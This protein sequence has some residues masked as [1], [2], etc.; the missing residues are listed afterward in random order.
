MTHRL[1]DPLRP[2]LLASL[3]LLTPAAVTAQNQD[4]AEAAE[5]EPTASTQAAE[6]G[7]YAQPAILNPA[8]ELDLELRLPN[9]IRVSDDNGIARWYWYA[10]YQVTNQTDDDRLFIPEITVVD[11]NGRIVQANRRIPPAVYPA[12]AQR[13]GNPLL[14]SPSNV[15]GR[16]LQGED[17]AKESVAIWPASRQDVDEFTLFF[18][19]ADGETQELVSPSTGKVIMQPSTDPITGEPILDEAGEPV[20]RPVMVRRTRSFTYAAPGTV[21]PD[22]NLRNQPVRLI[23]QGVVMR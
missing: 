13:L 20:M 10:A 17:F 7:T 5:A 16:L 9:A 8:W 21:G 11:N 15:I 19:G 22:G 12:I 18:A 23:S 1:T 3:A 6:A 2:L 14:E 4:T